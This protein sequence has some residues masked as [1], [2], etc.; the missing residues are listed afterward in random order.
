MTLEKIAWSQTP[1]SRVGPIVLLYMRG[2]GKFPSYHPT[3]NTPHFLGLCYGKRTVAFYL[4]ICCT[5]HSTVITTTV[6]DAI[7]YI[8]RYYPRQPPLMVQSWHRQWVHEP[9]HNYTAVL[10]GVLDCICH[11][12]PRSDPYLGILQLPDTWWERHSQSVEKGSRAIASLLNKPW[13][14]AARAWPR[15]WFKC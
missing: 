7:H 8:D 13:C 15:S 1:V 2:G 4:Q 10:N 6:R 11:Q 3:R 12:S 5:K 9:V 14:F